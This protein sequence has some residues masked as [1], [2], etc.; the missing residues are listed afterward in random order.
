M[1]DV[2]GSLS[3]TECN[4]DR[5][6]ENGEQHISQTSKDR[7]DADGTQPHYKVEP[8]LEDVPARRNQEE[9]GT[10]KESLLPEEPAGENILHE[11]PEGQLFV[12]HKVIKDLS[13]QEASAEDMAFREGHPWK[14]IPLS[15]SDLEESMQKERIVHQPLEQREDENTAY[16]AAEIEWLG[17]Q[18]SSQVDI[19]HSKCDEEPEVWDEEINEEDAD[20]CDDDEDEVRVIEF[21]RK[22]SEGFQLKEENH[23][24]ED[25]PLSSPSSQPGTPDEQPMLGRKG[26]ISRNVYSRYNTISY[27]KIRKGNTK[28]RIDEFESM[29]HL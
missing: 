27:R 6:P 19:L 18:K 22:H 12:I 15:S 23:P 7:A 3:G 1:T 20:D 17:F 2:P 24:S 29:M 8:S 9:S 13:L 26:D 11:N 21:K 5:P 25:S 28:Q 14:K 16:Q 4:G 10:S